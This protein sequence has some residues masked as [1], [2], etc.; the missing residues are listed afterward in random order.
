MDE[1][2]FH[3]GERAIQKRAGVNESI[4]ERGKR[5]IRSYM[6][7]QHR[8]FF[9]TLP[10]IVIGVLDHN[11]IPWAVMRGG[12]QGFICSPDPE[13]LII[14]APAT[15]EHSLEI[16][17]GIGS[18][19]GLVG[20]ELATRRRNRLNGTVVEVTADTTVIKVDQSFGNC[21]QYIQKRD[22]EAD[23]ELVSS[24]TDPS[25]TVGDTLTSED[26]S[27]IQSADTFFIAS[28][29]GTL[30]DIPSAGVDVSHRGG[31]PGFVRVVDQNQL[32]FPD[33]SGNKFF[34]TLGNIIEDPRVGLLF[35]GFETGTV[36]NLSGRAEIIWDGPSLENFQGAERLV[37]IAV[38]KTVRLDGIMP[39]RARLKEPWPLLDKTGDW[40]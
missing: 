36:L 14:T 5:L 34:N 10:F 21:A 25:N 37:S 26:V 1:P 38:D 28:R 24:S 27:L 31:K 6:P 3:S 32:M 35:P 15:H 29:A 18:K 17:A 19:V 22:V 8:T 20:I 23:G 13:T 4:A 39:I 9:E 40:H 30:G 11:G 12:E 33:F 2:A 16:T 7:D